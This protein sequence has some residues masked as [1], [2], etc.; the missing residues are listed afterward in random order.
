MLPAPWPR[1]NDVHPDWF[2][3]APRPFGRSE[4]T[5]QISSS[6]RHLHSEGCLALSAE[7]RPLR[8]PSRRE[9]TRNRSRRLP[10]IGVDMLVIDVA[11]PSPG[12]ASR[13]SKCAAR[14]ISTSCPIALRPRPLPQTSCDTPPGSFP[15]ACESDA[16]SLRLFRSRLPQRCRPAMPQPAFPAV[17]ARGAAAPSRAIRRR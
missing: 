13:L 7:G 4:V 11:P 9:A 10:H 14:R 17:P 2:Q 12:N 1:D 16:A 8:G 3:A 6:N 5:L 15:A